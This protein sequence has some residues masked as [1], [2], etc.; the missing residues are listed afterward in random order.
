[1]EEAKKLDEKVEE[2]KIVTTKGRKKGGKKDEKK[3]EERKEPF[4]LQEPKSYKRRNHLV[5]IEKEMQKLWE[6]EKPF[7]SD[8]PSDYSELS[9]EEKNKQKFFNTFPFPYM[10]GALHLGIRNFK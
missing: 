7:Y 9:F 2:K 5:E 10:N 1:M 4:R 6:E 8:A 3:K